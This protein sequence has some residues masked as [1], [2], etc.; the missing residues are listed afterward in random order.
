MRANIRAVP[1]NLAQFQPANW[2]I[3]KFTGKWFSKHLLKIAVST[4][5]RPA[6]TNNAT[7]TTSYVKRPALQS[8]GST[9]KR[10]KWFVALCNHGCGWKWEG[11]AWIHMAKTF[12]KWCCVTTYRANEIN[13]SFSGLTVY[14]WIA[15]VNT[16]AKNKFGTN[17]QHTGK[18][19]NQS[20]QAR[21]EIWIMP[22]KDRFKRSLICTYHKITGATVVMVSAC[23]HGF[24]NMTQNEWQFFGN[25]F[26]TIVTLGVLLLLF[27]WRYGI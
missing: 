5:A 8:G 26:H 24:Q 14:Q 16:T 27:L 7:S 1:L 18:G 3:C 20:G 22:N 4:N 10:P 9:R 17:I 13:L 15:G 25:H 19:T 2:K 23:H 11:S 6:G 21:G 12:H